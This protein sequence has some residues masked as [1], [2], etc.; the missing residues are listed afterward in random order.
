MPRLV[1]IN[2][3]KSRTDLLVS[4][5]QSQEGVI[6]VNVYY[7]V[8]NGGQADVI[9]ITILDSHEND[10]ML[11]LGSLGIEDMIITTSELSSVTST[12]FAKQI[13]EDSSEANWEEMEQE[14]AKESNPTK[15]VLG[16]MFTSGI[17]AAIGIATNSLHTVIGAMIIAPGFLPFVRIGLGIVSRNN[18]WK[19]G[20]MSALKGYI[21]IIIGSV[22]ATLFLVA[23][24][25]NPLG[26]KSTYLPSFSLFSYWTSITPES[27][28]ISI[29]AIIAG[30]ILVASRKTTLTSGVLIALALVPSAALIGVGVATLNAEIVAASTLRWVI[31]V[32][33]IISLSTV[34]LSWKRKAIH[35]RNS[36]V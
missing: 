20:I 29:A 33:L 17:I 9:E 16:L 2:L 21:V 14:I 34:L 28:T 27:I 30:A 13:A 8:S 19:R 3:D 22:I 18:S 10:L 25:I 32:I 1:S 7:G 24:N 12:K 15:N 26:E 6:S 35:K 23:I 31:D 5:I 4:R 36:W 11:L